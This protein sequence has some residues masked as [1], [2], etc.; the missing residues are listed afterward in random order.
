M[1]A[2]GWV[3][4]AALWLGVGGWVATALHRSDWPLSTAAWAIIGWPV[5]LPMVGETRPTRPDQ[6]RIQRATTALARALQAAGTPLPG[7]VGEIRTALLGAERRKE[8]CAALLSESVDA[9]EADRTR[10]Q[11]AYLEATTAIDETL[12]TMATMQFEL[13]LTA[14]S[15]ASVHA[16]GRDSALSTRDATNTAIRALAGR[17]DAL[18]EVSSVGRTGRLRV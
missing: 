5:M 15:T 4:V 14:C 12:S 8:R 17:F 10:L 11:L 1:S 16:T 18:R 6:A 3:V 2:A 9:P 13:E 7:E